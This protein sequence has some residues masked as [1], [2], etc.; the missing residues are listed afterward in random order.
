MTFTFGLRAWPGFPSDDFTVYQTSLQQNDGEVWQW[1]DGSPIDWAALADIPSPPDLGFSLHITLPYSLGAIKIE[2]A[3]ENMAKHLGD[4]L[5]RRFATAKG[6]DILPFKPGDL[7]NTRYN[8]QRPDGTTWSI[9]ATSYWAF[10]YEQYRGPAFRQRV[11][12]AFRSE[13]N[14]D[15]EL[16]DNDW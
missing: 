3:I 13:S 10:W 5:T 4:P 15:L 2:N 9:S 1:W 11:A 16:A 12:T 6:I 7:H 8:V 14:R